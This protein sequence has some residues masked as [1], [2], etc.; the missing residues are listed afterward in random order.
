LLCLP[1]L[2]LLWCSGSV[3]YDPLWFA[4]WKLFHCW[5]VWRPCS[6]S[7]CSSLLVS[8]VTIRTLS[9]NQSLGTA[10]G[11]MHKRHQQQ[12]SSW[13]QLAKQVLSQP[14]LMSLVWLYIDGGTC[15]SAGGVADLHHLPCRMCVEMTCLLSCCHLAVA[16]TELFS[17]AYHW[18][19]FSP[20]TNRTEDQDA[21]VSDEF[22]CGARSCPPAY[23]TCQASMPT[24]T[25]IR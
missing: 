10:L 17:A 8:A 15:Q 23:P 6:S 19:C 18:T 16:G 14:T 1:I 22:S 21:H 2:W 4:S 13:Q 11:C 12:H 9:V 24:V 7:S 20:S 25:V 5:S 3:P